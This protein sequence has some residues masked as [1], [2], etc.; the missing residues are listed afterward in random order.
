MKHPLQLTHS[1]V[2][3]SLESSNTGRIVNASISCTRELESFSD[4]MA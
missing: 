4:G 3:V 1:C 2:A